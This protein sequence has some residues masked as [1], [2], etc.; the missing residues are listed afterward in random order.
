MIEGYAEAE[1][2][3]VREKV[4]SIDGASDDVRLGSVGIT[5]CEAPQSGTTYFVAWLGSEIFLLG[6]YFKDFTVD[7]SPVSKAA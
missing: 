4:A 7:P 5:A 6:I 1:G 3:N 2:G